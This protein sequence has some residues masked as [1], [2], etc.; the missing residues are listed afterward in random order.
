MKAFDAIV[1]AGGEGK[2][3]GGVDKALLTVGTSTMLERVL[4][5]VAE[6]QR[7]VCVG[8]ERPTPVPVVWTREEPPG[9]GPSPGVAA[10]LQQ[11][12]APRVVVVAV[13]VPLITREVVAALVTSEEDA[14]LV[15]DA[16]E[17]PQPLIAAYAAQRLR[18]RLAAYEDLRGVPITRVV[19]GMRTT[20]IDA[21]SAAADCDTWDELESLRKEVAGG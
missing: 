15:T 7:I 4:D 16:D 12:T 17:V 18:E 5:A 10:G 20:S 11:V 3:L 6:A 8:L 9:G 19:E 1:L 13:D 21:P 14:A 2:R